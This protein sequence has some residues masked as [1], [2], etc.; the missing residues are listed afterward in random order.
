MADKESDSDEP[1]RNSSSTSVSPDLY[2]AALA[3]QRASRISTENYKSA[4]TERRSK[5]VETLFGRLDP[6]TFKIRDITILIILLLTELA[7]G[8]NELVDLINHR[9]RSIS[10]LLTPVQ[11]KWLLAAGHLHDEL[12]SDTSDINLDPHFAVFEKRAPL[13]TQRTR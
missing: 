6:Q 1:S 9:L 13:V 4:S 2:R 11:A 8:N 10:Q 7:E 12:N 5:Y 3:V